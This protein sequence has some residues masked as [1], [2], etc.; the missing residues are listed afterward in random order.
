NLWYCDIA[1]GGCLNPSV[2]CPVNR[3]CSHFCC[4]EEQFCYNGSCVDILPDPILCS[5]STTCPNERLC[6]YTD[7]Q[8]TP[9]S[10]CC[11]AGES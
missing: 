8:G 4:I 3:R 7:S 6:N 2:G 1:T 5:W 11:A 10:I 9:T